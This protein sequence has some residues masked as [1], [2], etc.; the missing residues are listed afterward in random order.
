M[1]SLLRRIFT[2]VR[3]RWTAAYASS[4]FLHSLLVLFFGVH[5]V[6]TGAVSGSASTESQLMTVTTEAA[7][8][9]S[10]VPVP[11][12]PAPSA[13]PPT[14][15]VVRPIPQPTRQPAHR[16][17]PPTRP[18]AARAA[19]HRAELAKNAKNAPA[20][21]PRI[22]ALAPLSKSLPTFEPSPAPTSPP[23]LVPIQTPA[24][25]LIPTPPPST[26]P[27]VQPTLPPTAPPTIT[28]TVPPTRPPTAP[29][30]LPPTAP[31]TQ[32][33]TAA[34]T[35]PPTQL[36]T[37]APT[38]RP[39]APPTAR[40]ATAEPLKPRP[41]SV[42]SSAPSTIQPVVG[43]APATPA[44]VASLAKGP[45][46][47]APPRAVQ[48]APGTATAG[49]VASPGVVTK[50]G[51]QAGNAPA[52]G[53]GPGAGAQPVPGPSPGVPAANAQVALNPK[54]GLNGNQ[55]ENLNARLGNLLPNGNPVTYS[56]KHYSN[57]LNDA[58]AAV[59]AEY[60]KKAAPPQTVLDKAQ[61][62]IFGR[63]TATHADQVTYILSRRKIFGFEICTAWTV[64]LHPEGGGSPDGYYSFGPCAKA[65]DFTPA[66]A[67]ELPTIS[68]HPSPTPARQ[69]AHL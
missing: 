5:I 13:A 68:P 67:D 55:L 63:R 45:T 16:P 48:P 17:P 1:R 61:A 4:L 40:P 12:A 11:P 65:S 39:T 23:T 69:P 19:P 30:T 14:P 9:P 50:P 31:P 64:V 59:K 58:I 34:P 43:V 66:Y 62:R 46:Q 15:A 54:P 8:A 2:P 49:P 41:A 18:R 21:Q 10:S 56:D 51:P 6:L 29:P 60:Y 42:A 52:P 27:T 25:V 32:P 35:T 3:R 44:A 24:P 22:V 36:P 7:P 37:A 53:P 33:P 26:A 28:P 47:T 38:A 20:Q 57:D